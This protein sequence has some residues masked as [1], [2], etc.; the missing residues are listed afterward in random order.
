[1]ISRSATPVVLFLYVAALPNKRPHT[2][3]S[4]MVSKPLSAIWIL[5]ASVPMRGNDVEARAKERDRDPAVA[6]TPSLGAGMVR[7]TRCCTCLP[8]SLL[9]AAIPPLVVMVLAKTLQT[10]SPLPFAT[11]GNKEKTEKTERKEKK[12]KK[13]GKR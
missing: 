3:T 6:A 5:S 13:E 4:P 9:G 11:Y 12:R 8:Q 7:R 1:M 10:H 2:N